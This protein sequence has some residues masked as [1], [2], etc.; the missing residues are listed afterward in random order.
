MLA[1]ESVRTS[2]RPGASSAGSFI[3]TLKCLYCSV[4]LLSRSELDL[5]L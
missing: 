1:C 5:K 3:I 4:S 2:H